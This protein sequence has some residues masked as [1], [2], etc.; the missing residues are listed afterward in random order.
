MFRWIFAVFVLFGTV[1]LADSDNRIPFHKSVDMK[2]G[3]SM[4]VHGYRGECGKRPANVDKNRTRDTKLGVLSNGRWGVTKSRTC[5]GWTPAVE[6]VFT[7][8]KK[9]RETIKVAGESIS[10]RVR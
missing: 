9:G 8:R 2:V 1:A 6:I 3:E 10:V 5:G 4:I 7:A